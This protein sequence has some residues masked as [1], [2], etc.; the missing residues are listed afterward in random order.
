MKTIWNIISIVSFGILV[1]QVFF[2]KSNRTVTELQTVEFNE[3]TPVCY[4]AEEM[5]R[6]PGCEYSGLSK[7]ER[8]SCASRKILD[9]VFSNL[10]YPSSYSHVEGTA[11]V[12]FTVEKDGSLT[13]IKILKGL[14]P[15]FGN[16][17][18]RV[19]NKMPK[20]I[21]GKQFGKKVRVRFTL[22]IKIRLE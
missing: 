11:A 14:Y 19:I 3:T 5:P 15:G 12:Q 13:N 4:I 10:K 2:Q 16:E 21:P 22:P 20:W 8:Q 17:I 6:F 1:H 9:F 18:V 7:V